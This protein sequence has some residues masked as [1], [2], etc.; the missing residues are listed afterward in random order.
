MLAKGDSFTLLVGA[1]KSE[2]VYSQEDI[3]KIGTWELGVI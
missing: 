1:K 3:T 2:L